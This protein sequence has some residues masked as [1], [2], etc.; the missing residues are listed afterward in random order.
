MKLVRFSAGKDSEWLECRKRR[1][2]IRSTAGELAVPQELKDVPIPLD[3]DPRERETCHKS[4]DSS[5]EHRWKT[6]V[7][8]QRRRHSKIR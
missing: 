4:S 5:C 2:E 3:S 6:A 1:E 8:L 7:Q